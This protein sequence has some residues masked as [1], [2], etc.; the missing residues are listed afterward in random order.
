MHW[1]LAFVYTAAAAT[2]SSV[3]VFVIAIY[4]ERSSRQ[5]AAREA[6]RV[7]ERQRRDVR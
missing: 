2:V 1:N 7:A 6:L 3:L 4:E 5:R